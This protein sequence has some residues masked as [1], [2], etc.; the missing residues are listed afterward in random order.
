MR[1][2]AT[3]AHNK[4]GGKLTERVVM[5]NCAPAASRTRRPNRKIKKRCNEGVC[6]DPQNVSLFCPLL[7]FLILYHS[8]VMF[9]SW[10]PIIHE[11]V[12]LLEEN[13]QS[14]HTG[15]IP[16][17]GRPHFVLPPLRAWGFPRT[18]IIVCAESLHYFALIFC[19]VCI[20]TCKKGN[21]LDMGREPN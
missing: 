15:G 1:G 5:K 9:A 21:R 2:A 11:S 6:C 19:E 4:L 14:Q 10:R 18:V 16:A 8:V 12:G 20:D 7:E 13:T 17:W 3:V